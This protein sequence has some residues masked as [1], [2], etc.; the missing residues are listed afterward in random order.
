MLA[1]TWHYFPR[2]LA[3]KFYWTPVIVY[4]EKN[5]VWKHCTI[6]LEIEHL[7]GVVVGLSMSRFLFN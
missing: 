2:F 3:L 1:Q 6:H 7:L 4:H 5:K